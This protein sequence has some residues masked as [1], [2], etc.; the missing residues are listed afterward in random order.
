MNKK[1]NFLD[2][3]TTANISNKKIL[4]YPST[5]NKNALNILRISIGLGQ[6]NKMKK[7]IHF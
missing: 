6:C 1:K 2:K 4:K 3:K 7:N 5:R